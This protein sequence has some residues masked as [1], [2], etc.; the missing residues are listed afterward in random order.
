MINKT[1]LLTYIIK[2]VMISPQK[3]VEFQPEMA[4]FCYGGLLFF[5]IFIVL[6]KDITYNQKKY[7]KSKSNE[8]YLYPGMKIGIV[9]PAFNEEKNIGNTLS[10]FPKNISDKMEIIVVDDGSRDKTTQI[11]SKYATTILKHERNRGNGAAI[12]TGLDYCRNVGMDIVI[13]ID[14][15]GQHEPRYIKD[16][17]KPI[18]EDGYDYVIGNRFRYY[19][20]MRLIKKVCSRVMSLF[21]SFILRQKISDPTMGYRALSKRVI[22]YLYFESN[23][24]IT[25]EMLFKIVPL[26]K[27][28]EIPIK[29]NE[30]M[31]GQSF[32]RLKKYFYKTFFSFI[33]FYLFPRVYK[34][35]YKHIKKSFRR[36][37]RGMI[38]T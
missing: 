13:I 24:S 7:N 1:S 29:I 26:F 8:E 37:V 10:R 27:S 23:Y 14:A 9:V 30:R 5:L 34:F 6:I 18:V 25:L 38:K 20:D 35:S 17:I 11:A 3:K 16:F 32:I 36:K 21:V 31:Y 28:C 2:F 15:D 33:K 19:Y 12:Q 4:F 22:K